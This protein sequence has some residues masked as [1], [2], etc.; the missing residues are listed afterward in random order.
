MLTITLLTLAGLLGVLLAYAATRPDHF[1]VERSAVI[2]AAPERIFPHINRLDLWQAWSPYEKKD[3]AMRRTLS[4]ADAGTGAIYT[5]DGNQAVG[6][7]RM[8][9]LESHAPSKVLIQLDFF[10]PMQGHNT[11]EFTLTPESGGTRVTWALYG[12]SPFLSKLMGLVFNFDTMIGKDFVL[13]LQNLRLITEP[14]P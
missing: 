11:A 5:W 7:G 2:Q 10:R 13:G 4:G 1:R 14:S 8:E 3:P 12:P 6:A 9:I